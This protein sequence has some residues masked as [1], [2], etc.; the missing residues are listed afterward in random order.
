MVGN[1][2]FFL[3]YVYY[4]PVRSRLSVSRASF[5]QLIV[6]SSTTKWHEN[7]VPAIT[8]IHLLL[9]ETFRSKVRGHYSNRN[10]IRS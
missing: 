3:H 2:F 9:K 4:Y 6:L 1:P 5:N 8:R 7:T 10:T